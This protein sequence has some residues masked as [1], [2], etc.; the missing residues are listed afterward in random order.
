MRGTGVPWI[1]VSVA[2]R[3]AIIG[4]LVRPGVPGCSL[5]A[6]TRMHNASLQLGSSESV[7]PD[8]QLIESSQAEPI[9]S[10][11]A[12][13]HIAH[14][15]AEETMRL[16]EIRP[17]STECGVYI[18]QRD[19]L[20]SSLH[21][22]LP[23]PLCPI[24]GSLP[25]DSP[26]RAMISLS[27][28]IK[29]D[30]DTYRIKPLA[31]WSGLLL[32]QFYDP[33]TG[34]I[35]GVFH[36]YQAPIASTS[37][38]VP[39]FTYG[40]EIAGGRG[41]TYSRS[42]TAA[43]LEALER[44]CARMPQRNRMAVC[45]SYNRLTSEALDPRTAG[46][47]RD[48]QYAMPE[49]PF[50]PFDPEEPIDWVWGCSLTKQKPILVPRSLAY[51]SS[52]S[53]E[54]W[55]NEGSNGCAIGGSLEEAI[56]HG[57]L[58]VIERDSFLITWYARLPLRQLDVLSSG[59]QYLTS[60]INRIKRASDYDVRLYNMTMEHGIPAVLAVAKSVSNRSGR[61]NLICAAGAHLDPLHAARSAV[62]E[63]AGLMGGLQNIFE[64]DQ[65]RLAPMLHDSSLV[66]RMEDHALLYGLPQAEERLS[67]LLEQRL[68]PISFREAFGRPSKQLD[69]ADDVRGAVRTLDRLGMEVIAV[70]QTTPEVECIGLHCVKVLVPGMLPMTFGHSLTRLAGLDRVLRVSAELGYAQET[71]AYESLNPHPHP[72]P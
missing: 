66:E 13:E 17:V 54:S 45:D 60:L 59:D 33:R 63:A 39:S 18:V 47:Y 22:F 29:P 28:R 42:M 21:S 64:R 40:I 68:P 19:T 49:F 61:M 8:G 15:V 41:S 51:Y 23:D 48:E 24:C 34:I 52:S 9:S 37:V 32:K 7:L 4:P 46:L 20:R 43:M 58:E 25:F 65:E 26:E 16:L 11:M 31:E 27:S 67:F 38:T 72:F 57:L 10:S 56:L 35:N 14:F 53:G 5:C 62:R 6:R 44:H 2:S 12:N 55:V 3:E 50:E 36:D 70:N 30:P 69:L 1:R 71:I